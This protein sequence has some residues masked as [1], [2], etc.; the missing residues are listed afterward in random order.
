MDGLAQGEPVI[1]FARFHADLDAIHRVAGKQ[2]RSVGELS[3]RVN[4]LA[5]WQAGECDVL[6]VQIQSGGVGIDLTRAHYVMYYSLGYNLGEYE[7]SLARPR[8]PGQEHP[9]TYYHLIAKGTID[10][11]V[12]RALAKRRRVVD[13]VLKEIRGG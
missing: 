4:Q 8:R 7:Q 2:G 10:S 12:Y 3:G 1:V 11:I 5:A 6:A 13:E 9:V